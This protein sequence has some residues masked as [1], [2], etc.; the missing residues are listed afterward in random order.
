MGII[1]G[2]WLPNG[3]DQKKHY[4]LKAFNQKYYYRQLPVEDEDMEFNYVK[5]G[6]INDETKAVQEILADSGYVLVVTG[7]YDEN[8]GKAI[9]EFQADNSLKADGWVGKLTWAKL[10]SE[11]SIG[12]EQF[13]QL[14]V[15]KTVFR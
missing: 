9:K 13:S 12:L 4:A 10:I 1:P 2:G 6:S 14:L 3:Y 7:N 11:T 15:K 5:P 8:T